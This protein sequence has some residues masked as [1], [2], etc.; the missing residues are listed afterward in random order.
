MTDDLILLASVYLD[1]HATADERAQVEADAELLIEVERLRRVRVVLS[2]PGS[3]DAAPLSTRERH[4]AAALNIWD[5][6]PT[7]EQL[8]N[9]TPPGVDR[10]KTASITPAA[11]LRDRRAQRRPVNTRIL[12]AAA[13]VVVLA[14]AGLV[15]NG[16]INS[17]NS[18]KSADSATGELDTAADDPA[19]DVLA[20]EEFATE[21]EGEVAEEVAEAA[22]PDAAVE[23]E[24]V[25][26]GGPEQAPSERGLEVLS[27]KADL[28]VFANDLVLSRSAQTTQ[29]NQTNETSSDAAAEVT[30]PPTLPPPVDLCGLIDDFVGF[31]SWEGSGQV[32]ELV[33]VG[34]DNSSNQAVAY[35]AETC[36]QVTSTPLP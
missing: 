36:T 10:T 9:A 28:A 26:A 31:A 2:D 17:S 4:L 13:A 35:Q 34:I 16:T 14:G 3:E 15:V 1:G 19:L 8:G 27:S 12:T 7:S 18:D 23:P 5:Q 20:A 30:A 25:A 21:G 32:G 22:A 33:A 11:G 24:E 6:L 29:T